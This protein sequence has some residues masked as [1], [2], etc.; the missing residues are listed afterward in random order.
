MRHADTHTRDRIATFYAGMGAPRN[1]KKKSDGRV[2]TEWF[3]ASQFSEMIF[4][5][6]RYP[7]GAPAWCQRPAGAQPQLSTS[8]KSLQQLLNQKFGKTLAVD[9]LRA[10]QAYDAYLA[11]RTTC[12][13]ETPDDAAKQRVA[14]LSA[15]KGMKPLAPV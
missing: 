10:L 6:K 15:V 14:L 5:G 7:G 2:D 8:T 4:G 1:T 13:L 9:L 3:K 12:N 11:W